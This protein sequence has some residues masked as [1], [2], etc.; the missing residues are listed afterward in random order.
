MSLSAAARREARRDTPLRRARTCYGHLAGVAGVELFDALVSSDWIEA[1]EQPCLTD[2][3]R[4][5]LLS[6]GVPLDRLR[7]PLTRPCLDWTEHRTHLAGS[8]GRAITTALMDA[9]LVVRVNGSRE[10]HI[11]GPLD[12]W[13]NGS[14]AV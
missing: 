4:A 6:R 11:A 12:S 13:L 14:R 10:V 7:D 9:G 2:R 3:G 8:V 5:E 1:G